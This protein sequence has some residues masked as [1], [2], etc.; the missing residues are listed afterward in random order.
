MADFAK[1][2]KGPDSAMRSWTLMDI[3][4]HLAPVGLA[5]LISADAGWIK[6]LTGDGRIIMFSTRNV[7]GAEQVNEDKLPV[8]LGL[9]TT[10]GAPSA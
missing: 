7:F 5:K 10:R 9:A 6:F 8:E 3:Q 1:L 2:P 4:G